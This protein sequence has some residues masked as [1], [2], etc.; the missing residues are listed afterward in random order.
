M[1]KLHFTEEEVIGFIE[2]KIQSGEATENEITLYEDGLLFGKLEK[3]NR[4]YRGLVEEMREQFEIK[5]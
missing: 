1:E 2:D 3:F 4:T 5:Y